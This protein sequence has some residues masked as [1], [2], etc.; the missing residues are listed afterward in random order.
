VSYLTPA[1]LVARF[2]AEEIAQVA[3]RSTPREVTPELLLLALA[4]DPLTGWAASDVAAVTAAKAL[5]LTTIDDAQSAI[6]AYLSGRY[7]T[8]LA[9]VPLVIRRMVADVARYYLHGDRASDPIIKAY[10]A[11]MGLCRDISTG[12]VSFGADVVDSPKGGAGG[13]EMV[14]ST[15]LWSREARGL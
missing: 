2:G 9:S 5:L 7:T 13:V 14:S 6:D 3:D 10:D 8:P 15:R 4:D 12:K 1:D 11:A